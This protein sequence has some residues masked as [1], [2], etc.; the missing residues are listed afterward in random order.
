MGLLVGISVTRSLGWLQLTKISLYMVVQ[1]V[2]ENRMKALA[3]AVPLMCCAA[4]MLRVLSPKQVV[5][6][7]ERNSVDFE[8]LLAA[9][10]ASYDPN[11]T[12]SIATLLLS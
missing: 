5:V 7:G 10:H 3:M 4:D 8:S 12:V 9:A 1:A 11:K 2:F 6:V